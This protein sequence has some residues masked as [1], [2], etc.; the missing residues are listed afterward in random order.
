MY[1]FPN[2]ES[3]HCSTSGSNYCFL[4]CTQVLQKAGKVIWYSHILKNFPQFVVMHTVKA[5]GIVNKVEVDV[6]FWNSFA[7]LMIQ[8]MLAI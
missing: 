3:V 6:F 8:W 4:I 5:F 7:F 2:L 1:S